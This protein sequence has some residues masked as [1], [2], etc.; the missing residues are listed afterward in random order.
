[1]GAIVAGKWTPLQNQPSF[2]AGTALLLTD[3]TVLCQDEGSSNGGTSNWWKL[4]PESSGNYIKGTWKQVASMPNN[5]AIPKAQGGPT[6]APLYYAS[7]VLNDGRVFVAGGEYNAGASVDL[8]AAAIYDPVADSWTNLSTPSQWNNIGDAPC[9]VLPDGTVLLGSIK[10]MRTALYDPSTNSW[11]GTASKEDSSSEE[12]WTLL[13]D[14]SVLTAECSGNP[15]CEKYIPAADRWVAAGSTPVGAGLVQSS[16]ASSNEIG[17]AILL[18]DGRIFAIG[19]TGHTALYIP[20]AI[21][22]QPG[23]WAPGPDFPKDSTNKL[24]QAFDAAAV[25]LPNGR[26]LCMAGPPKSDG[27]AGPTNF[28]EFDGISLN[29]IPNPSTASTDTWQARLLLLPTGEVLFSNGS[30]SIEIYQPDG[31]PDPSWAPA[32][33]SS[34]ST[35]QPGH[36]YTL[37]GRQINGLSQ[38]NSYGDDATSATNYPLVRITN[39]ATGHCVYCRTHSH[40]T[41]AVATGNVIH[42]THF[43][44]PANAELGASTLCVVANGIAGCV[45]VLVS[46]K[47]WKEIKVE[48][49]E[50]KELKENIKAEID[51][52]KSLVSEIPKLKDSEG[53]PLQQYFGD[54]EWLRVVR[55]IAERSD[56]LQQEMVELRSFITEDERPDVGSAGLQ[57]TDK[58]GH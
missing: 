11:K 25:L 42:S 1:M 20:P 31:S 38:A 17:P 35:V 26:V 37:K 47:A 43:D 16:I 24:M 44:V 19:A 29:P 58:K 28:F 22:N 55:L 15:K 3:G 2:Y 40:S 34:P 39:N 52:V 32:I 27:W 50:T 51:L 7:G 57:G 4:A 33:T 8:L 13:P 30:Q 14:G 18:N 23:T 49:K 41:M 48:I 9:C 12:T 46:R 53:D 54:P 56:Q 45:R 10:D 36:S 6:N 5:N 21:A